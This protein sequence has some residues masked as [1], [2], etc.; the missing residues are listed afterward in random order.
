MAE[1]TAARNVALKTAQQGAIGR[2]MGLTEPEDVTR[3][4]GQ[5][6]NGRTSVADMKALAKA[7]AGNP[8]ARQG[9][10]RA[11]TDFMA[12]RLISNTEASTS[13]ESLIR[14]DAYQSFISQKRAALHLVY[15]PEEVRMMEA[16]A[17]DIQRSARS[18]NTKLPGQSNT[19][20]DQHVP[21]AKAIARL[22][23]QSWLH[24]IGA[25]LGS[26]FGPLGTVAGVLSTHV[27]QGLRARGIASV[28]QLI[29]DAMLDPAL[30]RELLK[31]A[32]RKSANLNA[33]YGPLAAALWGTTQSQSDRHQ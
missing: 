4:V 21:L 30:A 19:A 13:G 27:V 17:E 24:V 22:A 15:S 23:G 14:A 3:T 31:K 29:S 16:V 12:N 6:L 7:T 10:R 28:D 25:T 8:E 20:Q 18:Q 32:P 26:A 2:V 11:G 5:I 9:L 1:A 33:G